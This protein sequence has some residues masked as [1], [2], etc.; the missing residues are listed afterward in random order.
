MNETETKKGTEGNNDLTVVYNVDGVDVKL[1]PSI[2]QK[3][4]V[5]EGAEKITIQEYK[6]FTDLCKARKLNPFLREAYIIKYG[7]QPAQL[8]VG[9]DAILKR[10][11][12]NPQY[13]GRDQGI[14]VQLEDG[15]IDFRQGT[16]KLPNETLV[17]G[18]AKVYRKD[19]AHPTAITVS[20]EEVAQRKRDGS[21]NSNWSS[22]G[23]TMVEKVALVR[24]LRET[25]VEDCGGMI[26]ADEAWDEGS[27]VTKLSADNSTDNEIAN[28][29]TQYALLRS[30][31]ASV[32]YDFRTEEN[33][34]YI[35]T[36]AGVAT[37]DVQRLDQEQIKRLCE[38]YA[39]I[40]EEH[41]HGTNEK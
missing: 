14:I 16:F 18:W 5:G 31:L 34:T 2:V 9:K 27:K 33:D 13:D 35:K 19:V 39:L 41:K 32:G 3:Y 30:Q 10:A 20:F 17:G 40:L 25:F 29:T 4:L 38:A 24:A 1:T 36:I 15:K 7:N 8:V 22:K 37:Q 6:F 12:S 26:D 11:I 23:A 28:V 21:L